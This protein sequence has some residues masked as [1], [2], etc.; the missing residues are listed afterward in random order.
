MHTG[1]PSMYGHMT[2]CMG[3]S[4]IYTGYF[5]SGNMHKCCMVFVYIT[6]RYWILFG[7]LTVNKIKLYSEKENKQDSVFAALIHN[8]MCVQY[9]QKKNF[10]V[11]MYIWTGNVLFWLQ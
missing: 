10:H 7:F 4:S 1:V 5:N 2:G 9:T 3:V 11:R 8:D 6:Q